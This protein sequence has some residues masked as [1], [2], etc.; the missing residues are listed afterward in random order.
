MP[1]GKIRETPLP[2]DLNLSLM[3][4]QDEKDPDMQKLRSEYR[5]IVRSLMYLYQWTG[6]DLGFA[7]PFLSRYI[8]KLGEKHLTA[9]KH[10]MHF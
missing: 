1:D 8:P 3:D 9:A 4:S 6:P 7:V 2:R 10:V 5:A